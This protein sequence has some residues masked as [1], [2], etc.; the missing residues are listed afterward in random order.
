MSDG[1]TSDSLDRLRAHLRQEMADRG[2]NQAELAELLGVTQPHLSQFLSGGKGTSFRS[3]DAFA[4]RLDRDASALIGPVAPSRHLPHSEEM[5]QTTAALSPQPLS[6]VGEEAHEIAAI[7]DTIVARVTAALDARL[8]ALAAFTVDL[9]TTR[10]G[11]DDAVG[12]IQVLAQDFHNQAAA[13]LHAPNRE[14]RA[15]FS[16]LEADKPGPARQLHP[17]AEKKARTPDQ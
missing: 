11:L 14:R 5:R 13:L 10:E 4:A 8:E 16:T 2:I 12:H 1:P 6:P 7:V 9:H 3:L 17:D 15:T